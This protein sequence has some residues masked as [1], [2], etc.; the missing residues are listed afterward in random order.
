MTPGSI[1]CETDVVLGG[2]KIN[3]TFDR[4]AIVGCAGQLSIIKAIFRFSF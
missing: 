1:G 4:S 2:K 3:L